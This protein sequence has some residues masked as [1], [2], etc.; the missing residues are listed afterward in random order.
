MVYCLKDLQWFTMKLNNLWTPGIFMECSCVSGK[1]YCANCSSIYLVILLFSLLLIEIISW[2]VHRND[3]I[4]ELQCIKKTI[5]WA[6]RMSEFFW[7]M[8]MS[9]NTCHGMM[10]LYVF[11]SN[12]DFFLTDWHISKIRSQ[13]ILQVIVSTGI[14]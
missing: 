5:E 8:A 2:K 13:I 12:G 4:L 6:Q 14:L 7:C 3:F 9:S 10:F 11:H 1:R